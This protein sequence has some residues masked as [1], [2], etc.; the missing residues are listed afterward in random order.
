MAAEEPEDG[1]LGAPLEHIRGDP[2]VV[3]QAE[4]RALRRAV[5]ARGDKLLDGVEGRIP[6]VVQIDHGAHAVFFDRLDHPHHIVAGR[7]QRLFN[8]HMLARLRA[9]DRDVSMGKIGRHDGDGVAIGFF[10]HLVIVGIDLRNAE[11][12]GKRVGALQIQIADC[13]GL[14]PVVLPVDVCM[15]LTPEACA[16]DCHFDHFFCHADFL[17]SLTAMGLHFESSCVYSS[18]SAHS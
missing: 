8:D 13:D 6:A 12:F 9:G 4:M 10:Q 7:R 16:H 11:L 15:G 18:L 17:F 2:E 14:C 5:F 3:V 1:G